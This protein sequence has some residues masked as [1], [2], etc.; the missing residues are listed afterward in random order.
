MEDNPKKINI[1]EGKD[2]IKEFTV[3]KKDIRVLKGLNFEIKEGEFVMINGPSGCGKSTLMNIMNGWDGPTSGSVILDGENLFDRNENK[4]AKM[5]RSRVGMV[6]QAAFWVK[7]LNV[8]D[9]ISIPYILD[10]KKKKEAKKRAYK[11]LQILGLEGFQYYKPMDLS[12][13]Q[14]QRI[15]L[16]R[17]L[18]NNPKILMADEPTGNLDSKSSVLLM[19]LFKAINEELGRTIVMV[20]HNLELLDFASKVVYIKDG[21]I[22]NIEVRRK[23]KGTTEYTKDILDLSKSFVKADE[24]EEQEMAVVG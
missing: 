18:V 8:I 10:G 19:N 17:S 7:S 21:Q 2:L 16:L 14:Q 6:H 5:L 23:P 9:N 11:L 3:G 24:E 1:I 12:G 22:T 13:G 15:S 20:T 4:R